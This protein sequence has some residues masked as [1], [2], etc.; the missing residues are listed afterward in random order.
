MRFNSS[1]F[2][3]PPPPYSVPMQ[4]YEMPNQATKGAKLQIS[5]DQVQTKLK[6]LTES[7]SNSNLRDQAS[8]G[9][10]NSLPHIRKELSNW[11]SREHTLEPDG[12][13]KRNHVAN[14]SAV[15]LQQ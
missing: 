1:L 10:N 3:R 5:M 13:V 14:L 15:V 7:G 2:K 8:H 6:T 9:R 11:I 4:T 12:L